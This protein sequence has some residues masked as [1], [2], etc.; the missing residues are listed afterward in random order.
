MLQQSVLLVA[1]CDPCDA[2]VEAWRTTKVE[3]VS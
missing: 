3:Y 2:L 1:K